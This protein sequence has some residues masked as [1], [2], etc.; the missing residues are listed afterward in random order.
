MALSHHYVQLRKLAWR[1]FCPK[2]EEGR[3]GR[4]G[5]C[6]FAFAGRVL[7]LTCKPEITEV[8]WSSLSEKDLHCRSKQ[9]RWERLDGAGKNGGERRE[10]VI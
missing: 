9:G 3:R 2:R 6:D 5:V 1:R 4:N 8:Y 7:P 10:K